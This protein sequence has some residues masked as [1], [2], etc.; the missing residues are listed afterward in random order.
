[1]P[2]RYPT[3]SSNSSNPGYAVIQNAI[4]ETSTTAS[5]GGGGG[6]GGGSGSSSSFT[7]IENPEALSA[8]LAFIRESASGGSAEYKADKANRNQAIVDTRKSLTDYSKQNAFTDAANL[9]AKNLTDSLEK[10]M[11]AISKGIQGAGTS[12]SS[13]QALLSSKLATDSARDAGAL[14]AQQATAYGQISAQLHG[15]LNEL[16]KYDP[17]LVN[18]LLKAIDLTK[19]SRSQESHITYPTAPMNP[20]IPGSSSRSGGGSQVVSTAGYG[21]SGSSNDSDYQYGNGGNYY[22]ATVTSG[23]ARPVSSGPS[24]GYVYANSTGQGTL[25]NNGNT[26]DFN[27]SQ[28]AT[29]SDPYS[30]YSDWG[31][32][33]DGSDGE[34]G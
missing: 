15:V 24:E 20:T 17:A 6:G 12:A 4:D 34:E 30:G 7:G 10:N 2:S 21:N 14:G 31:Y 27:Y 19:V 16:T 8:L 13:M 9:M 5:G 32:G 26:Q 23:G 25:F 29:T 1:M 3:A 11:P 18:N 33:N 28:A 22:T